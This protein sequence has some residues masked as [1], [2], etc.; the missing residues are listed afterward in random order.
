MS[1]L[2]RVRNAGAWLA[3]HSAMRTQFAEFSCGDCPIWE[4]CG[5]PPHADCPVRLQEIASGNWR[6][7]RRARRP[8]LVGM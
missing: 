8:L 6:T 4:S 7:R 1:V 2:E 5:Q 3:Y